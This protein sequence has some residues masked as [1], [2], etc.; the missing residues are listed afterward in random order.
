M[1]I[2][3]KSKW[4][5]IAKDNNVSKNKYTSVYFVY[6]YFDITYKVVAKGNNVSKL[7]V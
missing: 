3:K 5:D 2:I 4:A 6:L 1:D 7:N